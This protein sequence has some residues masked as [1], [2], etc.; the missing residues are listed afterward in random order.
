MANTG[1]LVRLYQGYGDIVAIGGP[2]TIRGFS[3]GIQTLGVGMVEVTGV[4]CPRNVIGFKFK[5]RNRRGS[6]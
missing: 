1:I 4:T 2:G 5:A 3:T 6:P